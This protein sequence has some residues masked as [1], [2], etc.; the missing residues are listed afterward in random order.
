MMAR[1]RR[2]GALPELDVDRAVRL[3]R[4]GASARGIGALMHVGRGA[5]LAVLRAHGAAIR[6]S[7]HRR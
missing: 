5:V 1:H 6:R 7:G 2:S 4:A 3:Y